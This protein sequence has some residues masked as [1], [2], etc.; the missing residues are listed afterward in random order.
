MFNLLR[1]EW[2]KATKNIAL[3]SFLMWILP[4][5][6]AAS[7]AIFVVF[8]Y[9]SEAMHTALDEFSTG[10]WTT[11]MIV[12]WTFVTSFPANIF[13]R[14]SPLAFIAVGFAGEYQW[15]TWK[16]IVPRSRR[17]SL[18]L[19]KLVVLIAIIML[20]LLVTSLVLGMMQV[21]GHAIRAVPYGPSLSMEV[22][23][24]FSISYTQMILV[25]LLSVAIL[26]GSGALAAILTR[27]ILGG[28][29]V[30]FFF[31]VLDA[32]SMGGLIFLGSL[33]DKPDL[34][35]LYIYTPSYNFDNLRSWFET[36]SAYVPMPTFTAS[37]GA[38][39][40]LAILLA[41]ILFLVGASI[42]IFRKQDIT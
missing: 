6:V 13:G 20:T 4:I 9:F 31:S 38:G 24:E 42:L 8:G 16:N 33:F 35:N 28:L 37:P 15:D 3:I 34:I 10:Q 29:L 25:A 39:I 26:G 19:G 1:S 14:M 12:V 17:T 21:I 36:G 27:S 23:R 22:L 11:D 32:M 5:G 41:W 7:F 40:S 18:I 2:M 30:S